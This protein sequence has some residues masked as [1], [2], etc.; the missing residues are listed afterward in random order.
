LTE[1]DFCSWSYTI[2]DLLRFLAEHSR[3]PLELLQK[4]NHSRYF[5]EYFSQKGVNAKTV[6]VEYNY[7]DRDFLLD[8]AGYYARC[9]RKYSRHCARLH[10]FSIEFSEQE[11]ESVLMGNADQLLNQLKDKGSYLGF[12]VAKPIPYTVVGRTCL[13]TYEEAGTPRSYPN[14]RT[15]DV[16]LFGIELSVSTLAFQEQ[17]Q[18]VSACATSALW[19]AFQATGKLF[20]HNIPPPIEITKFAYLVESELEPRAMPNRG[21]S[22]RQIFHAIRA[23]GLEPFRVNASEEHVLKS[24]VYG[25][26]KA[27]IP[28][29]MIFSIYDNQGEKAI[30]IGYHGVTITGFRLG[31]DMIQ[32]Y[33]DTSFQL[34]ASR[35]NGLY[36]HDD[37]VGP[38][39]RMEFDGEAVSIEENGAVESVLS[40]S[41]SWQGEDGTPDK[42]RAVPDILIAPLYQ[43]IRIPFETIH[44]LVLKFD[45]LIRWISSESIY[46]VPKGIDWDVYLIRVGDLK[47][48]I[49]KRDDIPMEEKKSVLVESTPR[50]LWRASGKVAESGSEFID[51]LFDATE[52]EQ[53]QLCHRIICYD[54]ALNKALPEMV[55]SDILRERVLQNDP[56]VLS[57]VDQI[58]AQYGSDIS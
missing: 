31:S 9:F 25:Y 56:S 35:I 18:V 7:V 51:I 43:K 44:D 38:F 12:L 8:Y 23:V 1:K 26:L 11:F 3:T 4:K 2:D 5:E 52:I 28:L 16:N 50:F 33:G 19:S 10:F 45:G 42:G 27:G 39:A 46:D 36:A 14:K 24:T 47:S 34:V 37:Q 49:L 40:L 48:E 57:I 58:A 54:K 30:Y 20:Q 21:L 13:R 41:S 15:Y 55:D 29:L 53:G 32:P 6:V 22:T 17:D